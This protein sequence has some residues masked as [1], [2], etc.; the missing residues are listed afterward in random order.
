MGER[1][2]VT[3]DR[4]NNREK[5]SVTLLSPTGINYTGRNTKVFQNTGKWE[6]G[7]CNGEQLSRRDHVYANKTEGQSHKQER[8]AKKVSFV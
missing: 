1:S 6:D 2:I 5:V 8:K 7:R 4:E 3:N